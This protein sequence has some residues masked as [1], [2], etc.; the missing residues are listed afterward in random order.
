MPSDYDSWKLDNRQD[1]LA[2][3]MRDAMFPR[4]DWCGYEICDE[5]CHDIAGDTVCES[6]IE[7]TKKPAIAA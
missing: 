6:C 4:C 2:R 5:W 1:E 3:E 7:Q